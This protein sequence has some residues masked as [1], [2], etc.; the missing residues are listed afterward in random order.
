MLKLR[1]D[2]DYDDGPVLHRVREW[3]LGPFWVVRRLFVHEDYPHDDENYVAFVIRIPL[4]SFL[5]WNWW[6]K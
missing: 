4:P 6:G 5:R 1:Q 2:L 3:Q